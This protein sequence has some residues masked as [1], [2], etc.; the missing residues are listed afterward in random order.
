LGKDLR[1]LRGMTFVEPI[2]KGKTIDDPAV[3]SYWPKCPE[4]KP[5]FIHF[6]PE[7]SPN[8]MGPPYYWKGSVTLYQ[9]DYQNGMAAN[10]DILLNYAPGSEPLLLFSER[11]CVPEGTS[12]DARCIGSIYHRVDPDQCTLDGN[13]VLAGDIYIDQNKYNLNAV[14]RY[15]GLVWLI[16]VADGT[17]Q[18]QKYL[19]ATADGPIKPVRSCLFNLPIFAK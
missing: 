18:Y 1:T 9:V 8:G 10:Q 12:A 3:H 6:P 19:R 11:L 14:I 17:G 16:A 13:V 5:G 7:D 4:L 15:K 2:A